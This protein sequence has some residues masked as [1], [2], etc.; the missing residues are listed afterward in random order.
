MSV[1]NNRQQLTT[2]KTLLENVPLA[3]ALAGLADQTLQTA[4]EPTRTLGDRLGAFEQEF[5]ASASSAYGVHIKAEESKE[6]IEEVVGPTPEN[7][8]VATALLATVDLSYASETMSN[9]MNSMHEPLLRAINHIRGLKAAIA[10]YEG[11]ALQAGRN[12]KTAMTTREIALE[13]LTAYISTL[14]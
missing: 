11:L 2:A 9:H 14:R 10:D 4:E 5:L 6:I 13:S 3:S 12:G 7:R 8:D 1:E